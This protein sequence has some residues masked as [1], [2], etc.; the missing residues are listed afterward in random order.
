MPIPKVNAAPDP[1]LLGRYV[2]ISYSH[3]DYDAAA[4]FFKELCALALNKESLGLRKDRIFF[5]QEKLK[6]GDRW[7]DSI[8]TSLRRSDLFF[9]LVSPDSTLSEFCIDKE[10]AIAAALQITIIPVLLERT[11]YWESRVV[12]GDPDGGDLGSFNAVP[13]NGGNGPDPIESGQWP[14]P[15]HGRAAAIEQIA[16]RLMRDTAAS[17]ARGMEP[18]P[19]PGRKTPPF[20]LLPAYCNQVPTEN[21]FLDGLDLWSDDRALVV[22][23]KGVFD[24]DAPACWDRLR[25]D[26][27]AE[28][29]EEKGLAL[30]STRPMTLPRAAEAGAEASSL[31]LA[32]RRSL[33][34]AVFDNSRR[35]GPGADLAPA[36]KE[37]MVLLCATLPEQS[38]DDAAKV[39]AALLGVLDELLAQAPANRLVVA[40]V[41]ENPA[42]VANEK[43]VETLGLAA[44][45]ARC[46]IVETRALQPLGRDDVLVWYR[47]YE[48]EDQIRVDEARLLDGIFAASD[49]VRHR[50]FDQHMKELLKPTRGQIA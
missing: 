46:H 35:L 31:A 5:D 32:L 21:S 41:V 37:S 47:A 36:L 33:S 26:K 29:C 22:L 44:R 4:A 40:I 11:P 42:L 34:S 25:D 18:K 27:L 14:S 15:R 10:L 1:G 28:Y 2:F 13:I 30:P 12:K 23:V 38:Q 39:L 19:P 16:G 43:L 24:D 45:S 48:L 20:K 3:K 8:E 50:F 17:V 7:S 49:K 6:A 9:F